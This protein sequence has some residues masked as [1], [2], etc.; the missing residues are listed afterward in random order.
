MEAPQVVSPLR[1]AFLV[2]SLLCLSL[3]WM[4]G[5]SR[6]EPAVGE[7]GAAD[8][9]A[10]TSSRRENADAKSAGRRLL[11]GVVERAD[12]GALPERNAAADVAKDASAP[13]QAPNNTIPPLT[14]PPLVP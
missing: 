2:G 1:I 12:L 10:Q 6:A 4:V 9:V 11:C 14:P 8:D 13:A 5:C 7:E 3:S